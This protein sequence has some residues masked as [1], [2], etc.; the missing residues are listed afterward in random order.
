MGVRREG[1]EAAVQYLYQR[2]L[3]PTSEN[4]D[5]QIFYKMRGLSPAA[6][7]FSDTLIPGV[8]EHQDEIDELIRKN[9]ENYELHRISAVD[10]NILRLAIFEMLHCPETPPVVSINEAIEIAKKYSTDESGRFVN[11]VLDRIRATLN[12]PART[13]GTPA[14]GDS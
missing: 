4:A 6:R 11:G 1:R 8:L 3:N 5:L 7:R 9:A 2:D 10:R 13:A 14:R 12:R